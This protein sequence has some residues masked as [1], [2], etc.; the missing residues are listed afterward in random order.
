MTTKSPSD[1]R[2]RHGRSATIQ[3][4]ALGVFAVLAVLAAFVFFGEDSGTGGGGHLGLGSSET[5]AVVT[6]R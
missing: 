3:W 6:Y 2:S 1:Q 4:I 5:T